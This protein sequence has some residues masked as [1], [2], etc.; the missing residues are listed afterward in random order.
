MTRSRLS[1]L[2]AR[3]RTGSRLSALGSRLLLG[4]VVG[5][6]LLSCVSKEPT[7]SADLGD[8]CG[9]TIPVEAFGSTIVVVRDFAFTPQEVRVAPGGKVTWVNCDASDSPAHTSSADAGAWASPLLQPGATFTHTFADEGVFPYH[10]EPHP[11]MQATVRV[12]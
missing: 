9:A 7:A 6:A 8:A 12:E 5:A 10:C 2:G 1:A 3:L 11:G 4:G